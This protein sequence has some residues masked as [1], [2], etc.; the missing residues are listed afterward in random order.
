MEWFCWKLITRCVCKTWDVATPTFFKLLS[1]WVTSNYEQLYFLLTV[2]HKRFWNANTHCPNPQQS[3][4]LYWSNTQK[5]SLDPHRHWFLY[6]W[7]KSPKSEDLQLVNI[8]VCI[9]CVAGALIPLKV[10][11][12]AHVPF[13]WVALNK[14]T[15]RKYWMRENACLEETSETK[16]SKN[17]SV[18]LY[19]GR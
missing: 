9:D 6:P 16:V 8:K 14:E 2:P 11:I 19:A 1:G 7:G 3:F 13:F 10:D 15:A 18:R 17:K 5:Y 12:S 4:S